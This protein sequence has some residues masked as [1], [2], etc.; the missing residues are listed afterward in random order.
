[1]KNSSIL[2]NKD[3]RKVKKQIILCKIF[4]KK[5]KFFHFDFLAKKVVSEHSKSDA[6][7]GVLLKNLIY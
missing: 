7:L 5:I 2:I 4:F 6:N 3:L 1:M